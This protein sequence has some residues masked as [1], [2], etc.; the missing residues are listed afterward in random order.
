MDQIP[1][2]PPGEDPHTEIHMLCCKPHIAM[3]TWASWSVMRFLPG[4]RLYV[5]AD[6][7][8]KTEDVRDWRRVVPNLTLVTAEEGDARAE[9]AL[10]DLG[11]LR[12]WRRDHLYARKLI[13]VHLFGAT[14]KLV[15]MDA[16][17]LCFKR[18]N[19]AINQL[20]SEDRSFAWN[21]DLNDSYAANAALLAEIL[22]LRIASRFNAGFAVV[23]RLAAA[24]LQLVN[25]MLDTLLADGRIPPDH[26]WLEQTLYAALA[27]SNAKSRPLPVEYAV[28]TG[29][30]PRSQV[31]RHY[32]GSALVRPMF[33]TEGVCELHR[34]RENLSRTNETPLIAGLGA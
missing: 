32:V 6:S 21:L 18:P 25:A 20:Q 15:L 19:A 29:R 33:Y 3:A 1:A 10:G 27:G 13:D 7:S 23:P 8:L 26:Y 31:L 2:L 28:V 5:H 22:R 17:V 14:R 24:D 11:L 34:E 16:D 4:A 9:A 30:K 12:S